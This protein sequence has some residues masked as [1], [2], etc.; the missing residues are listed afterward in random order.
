MHSSAFDIIDSVLYSWDEAFNNA[1]Y[2]AM[3][4]FGSSTQRHIIENIH[5]LLSNRAW[6][7]AKDTLTNSREQLEPEWEYV[8]GWIG[9]LDWTYQYT[10][11]Q[12]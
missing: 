11:E 5:S 7:E 6:Q 3:K 2:R 4:N 10:L 1:E 12:L 8:I 9:Y